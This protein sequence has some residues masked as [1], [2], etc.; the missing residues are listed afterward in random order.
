VSP[1]EQDQTPRPQ[2]QQVTYRRRPQLVSFLVVGALV[3]LVAGGLVAYLGPATQ[4]S[5]V[6][7]DVV[8]LGA[9]AATLGAL[10]AAIVYLV[11]DRLSLRRQR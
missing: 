5:S 2:P 8:L 9:I 11:A 10:I 7:Q 4:S 6:M 3:G 1:Q